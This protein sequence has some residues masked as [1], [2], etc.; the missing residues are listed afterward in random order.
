MNGLLERIKAFS[1]QEDIPVFGIGRT[2][3]LEE[4]SPGVTGPRTSFLRPGAWFVWVCR[5]LREFLNV[6]EGRMRP[7]GGRPTPTTGTSMPC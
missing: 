3:Q 7:I 1:A 6:S 5:S 2:S 4:N